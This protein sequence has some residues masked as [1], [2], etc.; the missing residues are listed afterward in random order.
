MVPKPEEAFGEVYNADNSQERSIYSNSDGEGCAILVKAGQLDSFTWV[1]CPRLAKKLH[2]NN[3]NTRELRIV[4]YHLEWFFN[5]M[6]HRDRFSGVENPVMPGFPPSHFWYL[7]ICIC[8]PCTFVGL[9]NKVP[10]RSH[11]LPGACIFIAL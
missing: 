7:L 9:C 10:F 8:D 6:V 11:L 2:Q 4:W 3:T 5:W 1:L